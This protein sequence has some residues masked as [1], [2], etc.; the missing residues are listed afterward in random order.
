VP[1][2]TVGSSK[3]SGDG[4]LTEVVY[5]PF[6]PIGNT[7]DILLIEG[8]K[9]MTGEDVKSPLSVPVEEQKAIKQQ[10]NDKTASPDNS[11]VKAKAPQVKPV[12]NPGVVLDFNV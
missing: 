11:A 5:P 3:V 4:S 12:G 2:A 10:E 8:I 1:E 7:Q 9:Q 6:F